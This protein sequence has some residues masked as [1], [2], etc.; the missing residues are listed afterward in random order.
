MIRLARPDDRRA[1]YNV[2]LQTGQAGTDA[3][4]QFDDDALLGSVYVGPYL[5]LAPDT[6][7][8]LDLDGPKGYCLGVV[9]TQGFARMCEEL[10]WPPLRQR[11]PIDV[12]RR[13]SDQAVVREIY[14]PPFAPASITEDYPSHL[15]ID[16]LEEARG[17][18]WGKRLVSHLLR[19]LEAAGSPGV[20]LVVAQSNE[21]AIRFYDRLGFGIE[22]ALDDAFVMA[23][24]F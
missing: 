1:L 9:D 3:T 4:G 5:E 14:E 7:F 23:R 12:P 17:S 15:H 8:V 22:L 6:S 20:H 10:W 21:A 19:D 24:H 2:C 13:E 18:G 11:Y 16:L